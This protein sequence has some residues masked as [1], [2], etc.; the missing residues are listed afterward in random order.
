MLVEKEVR[1]MWHGSNRKHYENKGYNFTKYGDYFNVNVNDLP[2]GSEI[3]VEYVCD[4]C[5][6]KNQVEEKQRF[7]EYKV[8]IRCRKSSNKDCC[9]NKE[10]KYGKLS[11]ELSLKNL[12]SDNSLLSNHPELIKEWN[13]KKNNIDPKLVS[14]N[15]NKKVWWVCKEGHEWER[16]IRM[17]STFNS[18][19]PIC[20]PKLERK[21]FEV[22]PDVVK[23]LHPTKNNL[24]LLKNIGYAS[25]IKVWWLGKCGHE[26]EAQ[27]KSR[28]VLKSG[29]PVCRESKGEK[30]V[31]SFLKKNNIKF[32]PQF[33]F[34]DLVGV[35]GGLLRFDFALMNN[36]N[37]LE[38][39][40]EYD[41]E[42]HY[43]KFYE[44]DGHERLIIHDNRKNQYC[45][46]KNISLLRIPYWEFDNIELILNEELVKLNI[47][48]PS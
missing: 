13:F 3:V 41:G 30:K 27:V 35:G 16:S 7:K 24:T 39:L 15:S 38:L 25:N 4:Y 33:E 9:G 40:V 48:T 14:F 1:V 26:W 37:E 36:S 44:D 17:R 28:T 22:N 46:K 6:G 5:N 47:L 34:S 8:L 18:E 42:Y 45:N 10:C 43:Q 31:R 21:L 20:F 12:S 32:I 19:C 29:C 23:E 11:E 2:K